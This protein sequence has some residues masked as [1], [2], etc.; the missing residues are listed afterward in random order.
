[1]AI[2]A[3]QSGWPAL[4]LAFAL[5]ACSPPESTDTQ[6]EEPSTEGEE[7][8]AASETETQS[9][10]QADLPAEFIRTA[11]RIVAEDGAR[12]TTYLDEDGRYRDLRNGDPWQEGTWENDG[13]D[14]LCFLPDAEG[15]VLRCWHPDRMEGRDSMIVSGENG[16]RI[17][18][19]RAD[20][21]PPADEEGDED[22]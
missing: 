14:R 3:R 19:Q 6:A 2:T 5:P 4:V 7:S 11:W 18:L 16:V 13:E 20:Y 10:L 21:V 15:A 1:M 22:G 9:E 12:Y 17:R 8:D